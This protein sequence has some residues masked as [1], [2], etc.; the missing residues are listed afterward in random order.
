MILGPARP[1]QDRG[2]HGGLR[3]RIK[4]ADS[5]DFATGIVDLVYVVRLNGESDDDD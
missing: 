3:G 1:G 5:V 2:R 4:G